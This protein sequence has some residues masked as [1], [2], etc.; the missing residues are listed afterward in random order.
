MYIDNFSE[1]LEWVKTNRLA[2]IET[3]TIKLDNARTDEAL[4]L[5]GLVIYGAEA[6]DTTCLL[7]VRHNEISSGLINI[8]K[9]Y[10][11]AYPFYRLYLTNTAQANKT[12]TLTVGRASPF[13]VIDNR[14]TQDQ[15]TA[16]QSILTELQGGAIKTNSAS[17]V[18]ALGNTLASWTSQLATNVTVLTNWV[19]ELAQTLA[20]KNNTRSLNGDT[21]TQI[22][23]TGTANNA[24]ATLYTVTTGKT[25]YI[26]GFNGNINNQ[27]TS[28]LNNVKLL[29][30]TDAS[31]VLV[32]TLCQLVSGGYTGVYQQQNQ[33]Q[34]F[35]NPIKVPAGYK[36]KTT[37]PAS[38][39]AYNAV[40]FQGWE[41]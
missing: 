26:T 25:L 17:I 33:N 18:T 7:Q 21:G 8:V 40:S 2:S 35:P 16:L 22:I 24:T 1:L 39:D 11:V 29:Y 15:L 37:S 30:I 4:E 19:T 14:S 32:S 13:N 5:A 3:I 27:N 38:S 20:I 28:S 10:G 23:K 34:T 9:G 12:I 31:D 36:I 6:T 41:E